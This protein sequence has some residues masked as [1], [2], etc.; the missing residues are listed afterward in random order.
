MKYTLIGVNGNA[1]CVMG[2]V[3]CA[4]RTCGKRQ[5]EIAAYYDEARGVI[6][7]ICWTFPMI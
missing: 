7:L 5:A 4:M 6:T 2:Y 1:Y 3:A